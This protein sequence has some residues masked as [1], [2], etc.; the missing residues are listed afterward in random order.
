M[1]K[2][3]ICPDCNAK[4]HPDVSECVECCADLMGVPVTDEAQEAAKS[5]KALANSVKSDKENETFRVCSECHTKNPANARKCIN[6]G[7]DISDIFPTAIDTIADQ[8]YTLRSLDGKISF[9]ISQEGSILGRDG[10]LKDFLMNKQYV[11]RKH[12]RVYFEN[13][14]LYIEDLGSTNGTYVDNQ[15]ICEKIKLKRGN[16][17]GLGGAKVDNNRQPQAAYFIIG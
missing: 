14:E 6:C 11:S 4:N 2:F 16:E 3:K 15:R 13:Y 7:E 17:I 5:K 10:E 9:T 8:S 1:E 12:C